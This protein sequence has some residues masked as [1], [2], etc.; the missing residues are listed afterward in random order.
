MN[1]FMAVV[2]VILQLKRTCPRCKRDQIV[3]PSQKKRTVLCK[4]CGADIPPPKGR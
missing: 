2:S 4:F 3:A 1:P